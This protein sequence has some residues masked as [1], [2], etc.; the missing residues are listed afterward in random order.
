[1]IVRFERDGLVAVEVGPVVP[2]V[3]E[4]ARER[5]LVGRGHGGAHAR[6]VERDRV[7]EQDRARVVPVVLRLDH[8]RPD[9]RHELAHVPGDPAGEQADV[10]L[11]DVLVDLLAVALRL[12]GGDE[13]GGLAEVEVGAEADAALGCHGLGE[14]HLGEAQREGVVLHVEGAE[15]GIDA[16]EVV[17]VVHVHEARDVDLRRLRCG[18]RLGRRLG[19]RGARASA[20]GPG[21]A[22]RASTATAGS[23][24]RLDRQIVA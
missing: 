16:V 18:R 10:G 6:V 11:L 23:S 19:R 7:A 5:D 24:K 20:R 21:A 14:R 1:M 8:L 3:H 12:V 4:V 15:G 9:R 17:A 2:P 22:H 13:V